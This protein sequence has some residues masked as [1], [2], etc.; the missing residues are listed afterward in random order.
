M[1]KALITWPIGSADGAREAKRLQALH[2]TASDCVD[3][4]DLGKVTP[5]AYATLIVVGH[6]SEIAT[7]TVLEN[8]AVCVSKLGVAY[9][10]LANCSSGTAKTE[11]ALSDFNE[12][13]SPA[14]RLANATGVPVAATTRV[15]TFD[16]VG[17]GTKFGVHRD[18]GVVP[19]DEKNG[20]L[21][22]VFTKQKP[23]DELISGIQG[24]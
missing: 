6:R 24:L 5:K 4:G 22:T 9:L 21:W 16:E 2:S 13:W 18:W 10:V 20:T 3:G 8:L 11:G 14:Q 23:I 7:L 17:K 15:L 19:A 1:A 12:L